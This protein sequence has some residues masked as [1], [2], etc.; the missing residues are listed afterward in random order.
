MGGLSSRP[1]EGR[2]LPAFFCSIT[3]DIMRDPVS[4]FDGQTYDRAAIER[5]LE[6]NDTSPATG[7]KLPYKT[8]TPNIASRQAIEEWEHAY[9]L[10]VRRVDIELEGP[11][12]ASGSLKTVYRGTLRQHVQGRASKK[13]PV[14]VLKMRGGNCA[15]E[16]SMFL[17][18]GRHPNLVRYL[19]QYVEGEEHILLTE[20]AALGSLSDAFETWEDAI[21]LDHNL[22]I[23]HQIAQG[24]EY[25]TANGIVHRDSVARNVLVFTFNPEVIHANAHLSLTGNALCCSWL[26]RKV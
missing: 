3:G 5:W 26:T 15:M 22:L 7:A 8:L 16:A 20:F 10:H 6:R 14:T 4:T 12:L 25:L 9:A 24:M 17:K 21:T 23:M 11:P 1:Q 13:V 19:G 18:L 2:P